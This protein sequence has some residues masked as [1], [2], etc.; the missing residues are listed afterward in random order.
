MARRAQLVGRGMVTVQRVGYQR[1]PHQGMGQLQMRRKLKAH[2][3]QE[4]RQDLLLVGQTL[5]P[6]TQE[7]Q[8]TLLIGGT[9][10]DQ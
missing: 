4:P 9:G 10:L 6:G 7:M 5:T 3:H 1:R 8:K 2:L